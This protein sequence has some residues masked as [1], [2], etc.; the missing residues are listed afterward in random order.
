MSEAES[1]NHSVSKQSNNEQPAD[2]SNSPD[3]YAAPVISR[4]TTFTNRKKLTV[5]VKSL[6]KLL[7]RRKQ[8]DR[9][10]EIET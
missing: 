3:T 9:I 8:K 10:D 4:G 5:D 7:R 2:S 1:S 6:P